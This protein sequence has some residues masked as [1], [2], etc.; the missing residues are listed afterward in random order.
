[1]IPIN[2]S[3]TAWLIVSDFNQDNSLPYED[4]Y[5]PSIN[6]WSHEFK[7]RFDSGTGKMSV[8]GNEFVSPVGTIHLDV[9]SQSD[10]N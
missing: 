2:N 3:D 1:M 10:F 7:D 6:E 8:G 9:N 5:C 4:I